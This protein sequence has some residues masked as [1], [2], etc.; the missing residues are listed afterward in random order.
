MSQSSNR[1]RNA[2]RE[3]VGV[4][5]EI[6]QPSAL[7]DGGGNADVGAAVGATVG[8]AVG[9]TVGAAVGRSVRVLHIT[10][11][12]PSERRCHQS[13]ADQT[14]SDQSGPGQSTAQHST[15][16]HRRGKV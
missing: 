6:S 16:Q 7:T 14:R 3:R 11:K 4:R 13:R 5:L 8:A 1:C 12:S 15:A 9:A 2:A 10:Y